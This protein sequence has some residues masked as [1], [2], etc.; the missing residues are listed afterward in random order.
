M[1]QIPFIIE[2]EA[3]KLVRITLTL[4]SISYAFYIKKYPVVLAHKATENLKWELG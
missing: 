3:S 2:L 4:C 1:A